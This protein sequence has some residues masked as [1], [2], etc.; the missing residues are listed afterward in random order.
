M[1]GKRLSLV[2]RRGDISCINR[3]SSYNQ[4]GF[5][6][7]GKPASGEAPAEESPEEPP[8]RMSVAA[9]AAAATATPPN[10][11]PAG[12]A[13]PGAVAIMPGMGRAPEP[14]APQQGF[15]AQGHGE[16]HAAPAAEEQQVVSEIVPGSGANV[17]DPKYTVCLSVV[18][19]E[20]SHAFLVFSNSTG[21]PI[22]TIR[23]LMMNWRLKSETLSLM[24]NWSLKAGC[25]EQTL[26]RAKAA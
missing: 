9:A 12:R 5:D 23:M 22:R 8:A 15:V 16:V 3:V 10:A 24:R 7:R 25:M 19:P 21:L 13:P 1:F 2:L 4:V 20:I 26:E 18:V 17:S 6:A 14:Q 11:R